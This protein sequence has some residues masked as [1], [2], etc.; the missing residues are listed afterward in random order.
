MAAHKID[1]SL[2]ACLVAEVDVSDGS[3]VLP[4]A[5]E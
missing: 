1:R 2:A 4:G 5:T 3:V